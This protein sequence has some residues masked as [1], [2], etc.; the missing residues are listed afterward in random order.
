MRHTTRL[1]M[2]WIAVA[3]VMSVCI[4]GGV[5]PAAAQG[6]A[7]AEGS[8]A[9][10]SRIFELRTYIASPGK[11]ER[12]HARFRDHTQAL[13]IKHGMTPVAFWMPIDQP[14]TMI[15]VLAHASM[16]AKNQS[17]AA[18]AKDPEWIKVQKESEP[19]GSLVAKIDTLFMKASNYSKM[20]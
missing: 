14:N 11:L 2:G 5:S 3:A 9:P 13:F 19:D 18:F 4:F 6:R 1:I 10:D 16:E 17:W 8:Y 20:K 7:F 15:Y 12:L